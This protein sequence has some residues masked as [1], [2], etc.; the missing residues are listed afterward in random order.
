[1]KNYD[2]IIIG[3]D[4][5]A[6]TVALFLS[7]KM[8]KILLINNPSPYKET[9]ERKTITIDK[10]KYRFNYNSNNIITGLNKNGLLYEFL[11]N[12]DLLY[13]IDYEPIEEEIVFDLNNKKRFRKTNFKELK[14]YLMRYYPKSIKKINKFFTDLDRHYNNYMEQYLNLLHNDDYTLTSLMIEWGDCSLKELL[15]KYFDDKRLINEFKLNNFINGMKLGDVGSYNFFANYFVGLK[16]GFFN[17]NTT[18]TNLRN[19]IIKK[20]K[21]SNK[22]SILKTDI[23]EFIVNNHRIDYIEDSKGEQYSAKYFFVSDQP[24]EFYND[25]F[26]D[27]DEDINLI[28]KYYPNLETEIYK[29][30]MYL[31]VDCKLEDCDIV[32]K[33]Y[34]INNSEDDNEKVIRVFNYSLHTESENED[35]GLICLDFSYNIKAGFKEESLLE[36]LYRVFPKLKKKHIN[37]SYGKEKPYLSMVRDDSIRKNFSINELIEYETLNHINIYENLY[38]GGDYIRPESGFFGKIHQA[39]TT[40]DKIEDNLYFKDKE[41]EDNYYSNDEVMMMLRQ[42]YDYTYFGKKETHINFHIGKNI[43]FFRMKG[44]NIVIHRGKYSSPDLSI[45]T[46]N[47]R[48]IE[49]IM[50]KKP[51]RKVIETEFFKYKGKNNVLK[52]F[53]KAFDLDDKNQNKKELNVKTPFNNFGLKTLHA[54][55]LIYSVAAF[56]SN[57]FQGI[58]IYFSALLLT[59]AITIYKYKTI[60]K[61]NVLEYMINI[62]LFVFGVLSIF[63]TRVNEFYSDDILLALL[64]LTFFGSVIFNRPFVKKYF[65]YDYNPDFV[66]TKLFN[67]ITNGLTFIWGFIFLSI[68]LGTFITGERYVSVLYHFV[69]IG[70]FLSYYYPTIYVKTSIKKI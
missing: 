2:C 65:K 14:I 15:N 25:Y 44:K 61:I 34:Y 63:I 54:Y 3:N 31:V 69:F 23:T 39:V 30:T 70:F 33:Y 21:E 40:A 50:K 49:L 35:Y 64:S 19:K 59:I 26:K 68:L 57:H 45:Y 48:L 16:T 56:L 42:N 55:L 12:L 24:I 5:Y 27:I 60:R 43:Y 67:T 28:K 4:I 11:D 13:D 8:R 32:D 52:R 37:L 36:K 41:D 62:I 18:V 10:N 53:L 29:R 7:R 9:S 1:M 17:L 38:I 51:Y 6:L 22:N 47:D 46:T 66:Q 58:Y 20:I